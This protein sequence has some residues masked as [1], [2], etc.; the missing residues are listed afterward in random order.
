M[1]LIMSIEK[2][3]L[4]IKPDAVQRSLIGKV[5]QRVED[6]GLKIIG[7][8]MIQLTN[9]WAERL[10]DVHLGKGFFPV[11]SEFMTSGP[12]VAIAIEGFD[13]VNVIRRLCGATKSYEAIPGTIRG[14]FGIAY[15]RNI[16]HASDAP[17]RAK[18]ELS[19]L[20]KEDELL[21]Y[22]RSNEKWLE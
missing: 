8:K 2:T 13:A 11:L 19:V 7:L 17:E 4:V 14:D 16:V 10:Y 1:W 21:S 6:K 18:Y 15:T 3:L 20:F 9:E 12:I 5:I 22:D